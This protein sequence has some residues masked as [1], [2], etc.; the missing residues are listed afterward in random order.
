LFY[1]WS[2]I[3]VHCRL[4]FPF[5]LQPETRNQKPYPINPNVPSVNPTGASI[6]SWPKLSLERPILT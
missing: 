3:I 4:D 6:R 2:L 1:Y 5:T